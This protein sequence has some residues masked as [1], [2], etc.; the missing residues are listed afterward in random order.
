MQGIAK[1]A[2]ALGLAACL[3]GTASG[4]GPC[5]WDCESSPDGAVGV[6]DL[7][8]LLGQWTNPGSCDFDGGNL[9]VTDLLKLLGMWGPCPAT[10]AC[11]DPAD[12]SCVVVDEAT[13]DAD[14]GAFG[15]G[16]TDCAD[17]D[18]DRIPDVFELDDCSAAV[19]TCF[20][21]TNPL[22]FDTDADGIGDGD[23]LFGT[24][25]GLDLPAM[26]VDPCHKDILLETDCDLMSLRIYISR[27][28]VEFA[29]CRSR[30]F[31]RCSCFQGKPSDR[32]RGVK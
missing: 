2:G 30:G 8:A 6:T 11:C 10:G 1:T 7:L 14:G 27:C 31:Y 12:G 24:L 17:S 23:E 16:G 21:G 18:G 22:L 25:G 15:G 28:Y 32:H 3:A 4:G 19:S 26:G 5:P 13:C 9:G 20:A 29:P